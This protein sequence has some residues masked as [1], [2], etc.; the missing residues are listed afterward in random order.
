MQAGF[1]R[2][3]RGFRALSCGVTRRDSPRSSR[4]WTAEFEWVAQTFTAGITGD[5]DQVDLVVFRFSTPGDLTVQIQAVAGGVPSGTVLA[6]ATVAESSI[7]DVTATLISV[8]FASPAQVT[9]GTQSAIVVS[10]P[11]GSD[12]PPFRTYNL[13]GAFSN[14]YLAGTAFISG[15]SGLSWQFAPGGD[16]DLAFNTYV[17]PHGGNHHPH[18]P[19]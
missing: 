8:P 14:P 6:S 18:H 3:S 2:V 17:S 10:A 7:S 1:R 9:A 19:H 15:N 11:N 4:R 16:A 13:S 5:L 12:R